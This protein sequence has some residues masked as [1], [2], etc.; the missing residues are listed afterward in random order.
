MTTYPCPTCGATASLAAGCP[1]CG[2]GPDAEAAEVIRL[3]AEIAVLVRRRQTT[4]ARIQAR[5]DGFPPPM[6]TPAIRMPSSQKPMA[7][8]PGGTPPAAK[9]AAPLQAQAA[10]EN[11]ASA[12]GPEASAKLVQTA[13]FLLGGL[14]L[15]VAAIVF[16]AVA[17]SQFGVGGR[18]ALLALFTFAALGAPLLALRRG[19][20]ATAET[21]AAVGLLL[22]LLDGYA[23]WYVNLFGLADFPPYGYAGAVCAVTTAVA[24]GYEHFTGLTGP[25]YAALVVAQPVV[26]LLTQPLDLGLTGWAFRLAAVAALN[27]VVL[28]LRPARLTV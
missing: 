8:L 2:R 26:P 28:Y 18:A 17:W 4:A 13:L 1:G 23:A 10:A 11:A 5:P 24:A 7:S 9:P 6:R 14:L 25:R 22:V 16:T 12:K 21:F 19:L 20:T 15:G 27:L 3:D